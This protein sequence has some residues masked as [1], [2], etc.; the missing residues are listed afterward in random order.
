MGAFS[1]K[2]D[3]VTVD[4]DWL[5]VPLRFLQ[6][7]ACAE[8]SPHALKLFVDLMS[9][10]KPNAGMNGDLWAD[11]DLLRARG[12]TSEATRQAAMRELRAAGLVVITRR[13]R[14]RRCEL[15]ALTLWPLACDQRKLDQIRLQHTTKDYRGSGDAQLAPPTATAPAQWRKA[16]PRVETAPSVHSRGGQEK[17]VSHPPGVPAKPLHT[18]ITPAAGVM[19]PISPISR[20]RSGGSI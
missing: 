18:R 11:P 16:R 3:K 2:A 4:G 7:R 15:I 5:P 13:R 8:L 20:T 10:L 6:S 9:L 19:L 1:N 12:W 17:P 14:G